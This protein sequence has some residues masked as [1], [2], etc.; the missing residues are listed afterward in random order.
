MDLG[1]NLELCGRGSDKGPV[2]DDDLENIPTLPTHR[3]VLHKI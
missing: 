3:S 1:E 2:P